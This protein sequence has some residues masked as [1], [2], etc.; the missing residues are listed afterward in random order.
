LRD[1]ILYSNLKFVRKFNKFWVSPLVKQYQGVKFHQYR[2][3]S[4]RG[5][6][7]TRNVVRMDV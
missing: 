5:V 1:L 2:F 4:D 6:A 3:I 7:L